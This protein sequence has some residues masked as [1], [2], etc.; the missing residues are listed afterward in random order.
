M[1]S[2]EVRTTMEV[3]ECQATF[4]S[5]MAKYY[6]KEGSKEAKKPELTNKGG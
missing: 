4:L 3:R 5:F 6:T 2:D 1:A